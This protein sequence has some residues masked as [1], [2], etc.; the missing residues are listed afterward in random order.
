MKDVTSRRWIGLVF[1]SLAVALIIVDSTIVN[2]AIPAI[3][4]DLR[5]TSTQVQ[6]VQ[7]AYTLVF[8]ALLLL[9]GSLADRIGRRR[10]LLIGVALFTVA[11]VIASFAPT[12]DLLILARLVQGVGG[13]M[14]LP[15]TLSLL[16]ATFQGRE[17]GIAFA[18]WGSTIGGMAAVGP[19]LG[20]W[21]TTSFSWRWAFGINIPL[22]VII[23]IGV[24][25]AVGESRAQNAPAIDALGAVLSVLLFGALV[26][27]LIEGR[28][29]GWWD[30]D[31]PFTVAGWSWPF[32]V[33]PVPVAFALA[34]LAAVG[35]VTWS[36]RQ[37]RRGRPTLL[38]PRLFSIAS[39]RS[40]NIA[41]LVVALGEFGIIL[42]L[43]LWLQFVLGFDALQTGL[44][45]IA[46]AAG[47]FVASG[48]AGASN[49]KVSAVL[50]VRAGLVAEI[51]G[52]VAAGLVVGADAGTQSAWLWLLPALF[53]YG[54]GVGLATAQLTGVI[55]QDVPVELSGQ[56]SGTQSTARQ[57]GS[58][59]GI[60]ILGTVLFTG[61]AGILS[62]S[63]DDRGLPP[64]QRDQIVSAV[65]D[66]SGGAIAG[67]AANPA[68]AP[69]A[70]DAKA[71]F[72]DATRLSAFTAAGFLVVGLLATIPLGRE[73]R[74][75]ETDAEE[76]P[77]RS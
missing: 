14:M 68:T 11:S 39:F 3:V 67:L 12:G 58:A 22:G 13:A 71:A 33:S 72:S 25:W 15:S 75:G 35:F 6:W 62:S 43:P 38:D 27:G 21:L 4:D 28:T 32:S 7:E 1:I 18:V 49:G 5:I 42:S 73:R 48:F 29:L 54:F 19:L 63:L 45:L 40:G 70:A 51:V 34:L 24:L 9:F 74:R 50:I 53:V 57:V 26:F 61:T 46:L 56:G 65:V 30:V 36:R 44:I 76:P 31:A 59:L 66:S 69:I 55:L 37:A 41:A 60:A 47:S 10:L 52:V 2:V 23:A 77:V 20:G 17:R 16:N 64:Q 8:A